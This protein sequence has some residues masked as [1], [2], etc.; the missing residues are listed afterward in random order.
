MGAND[1][2][3]N[4]KDITVID[5]KGRTVV[6]GLVESHSADIDSCRAT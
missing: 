3:K 1:K 6:P 4:A 2:I 5:L